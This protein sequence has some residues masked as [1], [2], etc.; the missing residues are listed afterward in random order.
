MDGGTTTFEERMRSYLH[1][2][3]SRAQVLAAAGTGLALAVVPGVTSAAENP[4][5]GSVAEPPTRSIRR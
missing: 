5:T 4:G 1:A 3:I 2:R